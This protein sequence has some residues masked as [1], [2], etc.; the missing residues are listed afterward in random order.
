MEGIKMNE[1][2][3][4]SELLHLYEIFEGDPERYKRIL[5]KIKIVM[6]D[7]F[8]ISKEA[9]DEV[10]DSENGEE[11]EETAKESGVR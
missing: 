3:S 2:Y 5:N 4:Y 8:K 1:Q 9:A 7:M 6:K 10:M 11:Y